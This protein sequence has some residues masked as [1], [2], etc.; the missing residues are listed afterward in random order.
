MMLDILGIKIDKIVMSEEDK[1]LYK[2]WLAAKS[3]KDFATAD[4]LREQLQQRG[5][6]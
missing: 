6:M 1:N 4:V 5:V 3:A 2:Q